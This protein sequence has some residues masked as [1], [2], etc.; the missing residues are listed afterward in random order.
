MPSKQKTALCWL[1]PALFVGEGLRAAAI[2]PTSPDGAKLELALRKLSVLGSVLYVAA[3]PDDENTAMLAAL[4]QGRLARTAYLSITRGDGGQNLIGTELGAE[5]G[6]IRTQELL[7]ARRIDGAEQLFTRALDFGYTKTVEEALGK[8]G[9]AEVLSDVV[10][11]FRRFQPDV[12]VMRFPGDGR[13]GHGQHTA[14]AVLAAE[15]FD[16]AADPSRFPEQLRGPETLEVWQ[17]ERL[18]WDA[19]RFFGGEVREEGPALD[20]GAYSPLLGRS[21]TEVAAESRS[22]HKSQGFGSAGSRGSVVTRLEHRA[23]EDRDDLFAGVDVSWGRVPGGEEIGGLLL[24]A[25]E[26][27]EPANPTEV[28]PLLLA[29]EERLTALAD[30][31]GESVWPE[32]K[33]AEL[34]EVVR[35]VCG[36]W[37]AALA[38]APTGTPG[39]DVALRL[40]AI[41]RSAV[42]VRLERVRVPFHETVAIGAALGDNVEWTLSLE[43]RIPADQP[44][45]GPY[46]LERPADGALYDVDDPGL[47][48]LPEHLPLTARFELDIGGR[49]ME[50]EVPLLHRSSD[51]VRGELHRAFEV[52][53]PVSLELAEPVRIFTQPTELPVQVVVRSTGPAAS[54]SLHL[55]LPD[56]WRVEPASAVFNLEPQAEQRIDFAVAPPSTSSAGAASAIA[57]LAGSDHPMTSRVR[58]IDYPH[59][60]VQTLLPPAD[61]RV[62]RFDLERRGDRIGYVMGAGDE[63]PEALRQVGYE[64]ALLSDEELAAGELSGYDAIVVGIRAYN[65]RPAV[66][67]H[68]PRLLEYVERGGTLVV[69][70]N[71]V[72]RRGEGPDGIGPYP[73]E[74]SRDRVSVEEAP[75]T[76]L[77]P[78]HPVLAGPNR[79]TAA[80]FD[81]WV[82]ERGL[83]FAGSWDERYAAPLASHDPGEEDLAG[84]LLVARYGEGVYVYTGLSFFREL[85]AGVAGAYRLFVNLISARQE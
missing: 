76:M 74:L 53:P 25:A 41:N 84:G 52:L 26:R 5:L 62:V 85:P 17:A 55:A 51:P 14:S 7:Q 37:L 34:R 23:G 59:I 36:L 11:I 20:L 64:V 30:R 43:V 33:L 6:V 58:I 31:G 28:L 4:A 8:W 80:D 38:E 81:G 49:P 15:A 83:Y 78:D 42:P 32:V 40:E 27:F 13:G 68:N 67:R 39:G 18:L 65:A 10:R 44:T 47:I 66:R 75:V 70:Y 71:T 61:G 3:H 46:W 2:A 16:A 63:I 24:D 45:T 56:G 60:P 9:H 29:A 50:L 12:V 21:F 77:L 19:S 73:F 79:I 57:S 22:M 69:Q 72:S 82:Q 54:G 48:G 1:L 35:G